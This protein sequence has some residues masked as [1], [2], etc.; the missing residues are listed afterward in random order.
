MHENGKHL[1]KFADTYVLSKIIISQNL[2][3]KMKRYSS[4]IKRKL[5]CKL[6]IR[7]IKLLPRKD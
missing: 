6:S 2:A 3:I 5:T 1:T 4:Y 7:N